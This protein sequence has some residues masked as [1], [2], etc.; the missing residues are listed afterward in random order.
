MDTSAANSVSNIFITQFT[1]SAVVV[2]I[3]QKLKGAKWFPFLK[4][5]EASVSRVWSIGAAAITAIGINYTWNPQTRGLLIVIPTMW[6]LLLGIWHWLNQ[7]VL[8]ETVYQAT[9]NKISV[10]TTPSKPAIP[11]AID[12]AGAVVVP[13]APAS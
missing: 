12:A 6:G 3:I 13:K 9:V 7:F 4:H 8:Q 1:S 11:M 2:W 5:G 10:T